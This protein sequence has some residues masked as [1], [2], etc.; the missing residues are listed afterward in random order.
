MAKKKAT[1]R[2]RTPAAPRARIAT[3]GDIERAAAAREREQ[4]F[5]TPRAKAQY[6][7]NQAAR[8]E[9]AALES[10]AAVR[11]GQHAVDV[12]GP[13]SAFAA[14]LAAR[15]TPASRR[16]PRPAPHISGAR[17]RKGPTATKGR[18]RPGLT[19]EEFQEHLLDEEGKLKP[20]TDPQRAKRLTNALK[21]PIDRQAVGRARRRWKKAQTS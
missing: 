6:A 1:A 5:W 4:G 11:R 17:R 3:L 12:T 20:S 2:R 14:R 10:I 13:V 16:L 8:I 21:R 18:G 7:A 19:A 15:V 9:A